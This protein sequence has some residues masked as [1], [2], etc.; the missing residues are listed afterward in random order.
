[1]EGWAAG[2][3]GDGPVG[4]A[5]GPSEQVFFF[6]YLFP[7]LFSSFPNSYFHFKFKFHSCVKFTPKLKVQFEHTQK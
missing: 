6:Y 5:F 3:K 7:N 1:V 2:S 4:G